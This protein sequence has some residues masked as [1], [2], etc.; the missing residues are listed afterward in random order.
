MA[1][2]DAERR[3]AMAVVGRAFLDLKDDGHNVLKRDRKGALEWI[4][5]DRCVTWLEW[6]GIDVD[7][8][9]AKAKELSE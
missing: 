9:R 4:K 5:S 2:A 7:V 8:A 6:A 1:R 3:L